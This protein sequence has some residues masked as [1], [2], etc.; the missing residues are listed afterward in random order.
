MSKMQIES[1]LENLAK[2]ELS[3]EEIK[4]LA[5]YFRE[6]APSDDMNKYFF[7]TWDS[8]HKYNS[9]LDSDVLLQ[10]VHKRLNI[11]PDSKKKGKIT[12]LFPDLL[13]YAAIF[14]VAFSLSWF[15]SNQHHKRIITEQWNNMNNIG[16]H[17]VEVSRGSK[18]KIKL[19]D[20]TV[21]K[22]NSGSKLTYPAFF[23]DQE[24]Q[25]YLEGE[26]YFEVK[27]DSSKPFFVNTS[28]ITVR[29]IGT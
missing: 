3:E 13:K 15:L 12:S 10:S 1:L 7:K 2:R 19:S 17:E 11:S 28:D 20:G 29:V 23:N 4:K 24:R 26:G 25:V 9:D 21:V 8:C 5:V 22:L 18:S 6:K 27:A 14:I 16:I